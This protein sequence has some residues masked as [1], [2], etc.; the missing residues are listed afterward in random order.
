[1]FLDRGIPD[2]PAYMDFKGD[3]YPEIFNETCKK[4]TYDYIFILAPWQE[5]FTSDNERY[6]DF[7]QAIKIHDEL[8]KT[9]SKYGY[10]LRDVPFASIQARTD[11]IVNVVKNI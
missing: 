7:D 10:S 3:D 9:Y 1:V 11:H 2:I 6:E 8:L 4:Y 5:I